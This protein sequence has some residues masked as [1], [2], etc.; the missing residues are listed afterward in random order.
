M[1]NIP[2]LNLSDDKVALEELQSKLVYGNIFDAVTG[3]KEKANNLKKAADL[4]LMIR[5]AKDRQL[6]GFN[7]MCDVLRSVG[8]LAIRGDKTN[9]W[10]TVHVIDPKGGLPFHIESGYDWLTPEGAVTS[11]LQKYTEWLELK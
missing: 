10:A 4:K 7:E 6:D 2:K 3:D 1:T 9:Y 5:S 8:I 11:L